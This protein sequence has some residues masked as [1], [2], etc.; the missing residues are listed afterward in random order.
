MR[1]NTH[2]TA[3]AATGQPAG[4]PVVAPFMFAVITPGI[5]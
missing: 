5:F 1:M 4:V 3:N 2:N